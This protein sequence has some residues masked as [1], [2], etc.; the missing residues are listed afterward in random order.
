MF[1]ANTLDIHKN[2]INAYKGSRMMEK[3]RKYSSSSSFT[4]WYLGALPYVRLN[5]SLSLFFFNSLNRVCAFTITLYD[6]WFPGLLV[7]TNARMQPGAI[8]YRV[9]VSA[10]ASR[11]RTRNERDCRDCRVAAGLVHG[12]GH[13]GL[14]ERASQR[15]CTLLGVICIYTPADM[16]VVFALFLFLF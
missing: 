14:G 1:L 8:A 13:K 9:N 11:T 10:G 3:E 7:I 6:A 16:L 12:K 4:D 5:L 2:D 15:I